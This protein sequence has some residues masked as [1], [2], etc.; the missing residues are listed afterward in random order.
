MQW[1]GIHARAGT[2]PE[3]IRR[4]EQEC[5]KAVRAP[6]VLAK[7]EAESATSDGTS[8]KEYAE[9]VRKEQVRWKEVV[10]KAGI[11]PN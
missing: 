7:F 3:I 6:D 9:F 8:A 4:M 11:K 2:P 10:V 1:Y 5:A